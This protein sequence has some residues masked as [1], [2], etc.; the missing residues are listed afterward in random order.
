MWHITNLSLIQI[1]ILVADFLWGRDREIPVLFRSLFISTLVNIQETKGQ[2]ILYKPRRSLLLFYD[3]F[4]LL[5][6]LILNHL[7]SKDRC[8]DDSFYCSLRGFLT[9][10][11]LLH[12]KRKASSNHFCVVISVVC[13]CVKWL[14][15]WQ[16]I[17]SRIL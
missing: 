2:K 7:C 11:D 17:V 16:A 14:Q 8:N 3:C 15:Q 12:K 9:K 1:L 5:H 6:H 4:V 13:I 10:P